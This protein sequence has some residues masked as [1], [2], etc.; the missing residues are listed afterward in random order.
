MRTQS[1]KPYNANHHSLVTRDIPQ[2]VDTP[3]D[4]GLIS[5]LVYSENQP[6]VAQ[7]LLPL[8][9]QLGKQSRWLLWL[10]PQQ[11]LS[12][13]WLQQSGLPITKVVQARQINP[14]STVDA[15]EKALLTGNYSVVLGWLPELSENDRIRLRLAAKLGNAYG[16]VMRPL[17]DTKLA[18][19]QCA[20]LKIHSSLYH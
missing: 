16:F 9:Q 19:G 1:L 15:M 11:K 8:L 4:S 3:T 5:E 10:T 18:Q 20:T 2:R 17:D 12:R 13:L 14:L 6:A 7:L